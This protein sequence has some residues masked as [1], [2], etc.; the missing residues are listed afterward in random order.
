M[1]DLTG[2]ISRV[3]FDYWQVEDLKQIAEKGFLALG[4]RVSDSTTSALASE[5]CGSPQLMQMLCLGLTR[6][7]NIPETLNPPQSVGVS[8]RDLA[9]VCIRAL[10]S[11]EREAI[12]LSI[13]RGLS[14]DGFAS[15]PVNVMGIDTSTLGT[16]VLAGLA[17]DPPR[18]TFK[19]DFGE[20]SILERVK[21]VTRDS[22][23]VTAEGVAACMHLIQS[24]GAETSPSL[25][26]IDVDSVGRVTI[27][28]PYFY[29]Y[30]RWHEKF[31][32]IRV[33]THGGGVVSGKTRT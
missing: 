16:A 20:D 4:M 8:L 33:A 21:K 26:P 18:S 6:H 31:H 15:Q 3:D 30:L 5:S 13:E 9:L 32:T 12:V 17:S 28:D 19:L 14:R 7:F 22:L 29:F 10:A 24:L 25:P 1:P 2:R 27:L 11:V 23:A